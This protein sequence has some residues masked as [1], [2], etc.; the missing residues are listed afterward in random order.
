MYKY[1]WQ[2]RVNTHCMSLSTIWLKLRIMHNKNNKNRCCQR[3][4]EWER[5]RVQ[6]VLCVYLCLNAA[7]VFHI[8]FF[9][10]MYTGLDIVCHSVI[11]QCVFSLLYIL[12]VR[13]ISFIR[14][15]FN[16]KC[17]FQ[18]LWTD[19]TLYSKIIL[20][21]CITYPP[22]RNHI[23]MF[24]YQFN[25]FQSIRKWVICHRKPITLMCC[26]TFFKFFFYWNGWT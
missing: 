21:I 3:E 19:C 1:F 4:K 25:Q 20:L 8:I 18:M 22:K 13:L 23:S 7:D 12:F 5:R 15:R 2:A 16:K 26:L 6:Y 17:L 24:H 11:I 10:C 9:E 14:W